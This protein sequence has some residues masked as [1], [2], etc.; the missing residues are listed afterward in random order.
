MKEKSIEIG[1]K[2]PYATLNTFNAKTRHVW[3]VCHGYG[4]LARHFIKRFDIFP[5]NEHFIIAPQGLSRLYLGENYQSVGASWM[6]REWRTIEIDN[7]LA[8][9]DSV[10]KREVPIKDS[11]S[12]SWH[13]MGFSQGVATISRWAVSRK[14]LFD[15]LILW[16]GSFPPEITK[17]S[18][19]FV[20]EKA[21][22]FFV[23]GE[24][25][26]FISEALFSQQL[27]VLVRLFGKHALQDIRFEGKHVV[28]REKLRDVFSRWKK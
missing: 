23:A 17:E 22:V 1:V 28:N 27:S 10:V 25:D 11:Q 8:Y 26:P 7:Y 20:P 19:A 2:A 15:Q 13:L 18:L 14:V 5:A 9:L 24:A 12:F 3:L 4:Q 6:T 16:A 21:Q